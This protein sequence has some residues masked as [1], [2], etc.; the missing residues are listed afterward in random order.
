MSIITKHK[1]LSAV[2]AVILILVVA[3]IYSLNNGEDSPPEAPAAQTP[4]ISRPSNG[5]LSLS[6]LERDF[7]K[8]IGKEVV[9]RGDL[10]RH[11]SVYS[12]V[13]FNGEKYTGFRLDLSK[14]NEKVDQLFEGDSKKS[15]EAHTVK[16]TFKADKSAD[17]GYS[18]VAILVSAID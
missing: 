13:E 2:S 7:T 4:K 10:T 18:N 14:S 15:K 1:K 5:T 12:V 8:Y 16:G 9:V 17:G 11:D 3:L 6:V